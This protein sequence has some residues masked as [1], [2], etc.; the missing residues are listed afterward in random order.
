MLPVI[1]EMDKSA[2]KKFFSAFNGISFKRIALILVVTILLYFVMV[3]SIAPEKISI[4][5]G[6]IA[7]EDI[8]ASKEI[9]DEE[10]TERLKK[11]AID[12][13][14]LIHRVD[15]SVQVNI[16]NDVKNFFELV[17][18]IAA[19][20]EKDIDAKVDLIE[21][22]S[23][24]KLS[25]GEYIILFNAS[26]KTLDALESSIYDIINQIQGN[27]IKAEELEYEK[28]NVHEI[29]NS[30]NNIPDE[31][32]PTGANI[33]NSV[34][35]PNRFVDIET[36]H[37]KKEEAAA[38]VEPMVIKENQVIVERNQ[39]ID[40]RAY[41]LI[42]KSGL[43]KE[44]EGLDY[45]IIIGTLLIIML[46]ELIV[47]AYLYVLNKDTFNSFK[48]LL[49]LCIVMLSVIV[50]SKAIYGISP[51]LIPIS[52]A[53]MLVS[54]LINAK[55]AILINFILAIIIGLVTGNDVNLIIMLLIGGSIGVFGVINTNQRHN[56]FLTG[57]VVS[58]FN[59]LTIL[60]FGLIIGT[61]INTI[62]VSS[63]YGALNGI[64]SAILTIGSLPLWEGAFG[65]VTPLKLLELSNPNQPLLKKLLLEA[66]GTY[67]HS[68]V[69]G[70][71]S[72]SAAEAVKGN[73]LL[74][75]VGSYYHDIGKLKR[76][77]F[78]KENQMN[79][80]NP[81]DK[82]NPSMSTLIITNHVKDGVEFATKHKIP[83]IIKD[84]I[85]QHH[86]DT[87]VA[88]FYH[89]AMKGENPELVQAESFRYEGPKPQSKEAAIIMLADSVEAAVRAMPE[90][91]KGKMEV[92]VRDIIK[93]KLNDGQLD[94]CGLTLKDLN[95][96]ANSFLS[97]LVGI[98]HERIEYPKLDIN[99]LKES[100]ADGTS[101]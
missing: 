87:M 96:I 45:S 69:V 19:I 46:L 22:E 77:Y 24:I 33:V 15:P 25:Q 44:T 57:I 6:D 1:K 53:T 73:P 28:K 20:E 11:E 68:I 18:S 14:Q 80:D 3:E 13:I 54:I 55:L 92:L 83:Q 88:Y 43:L 9:I 99:E 74:A 67:H 90:P 51:Y 94:E 71:L 84:I 50:M 100:T 97:I 29:F 61:D 32:K 58:G 10:T 37:Q 66:P 63:M 59:I 52:A 60:G 36:T 7:T 40:E 101:N 5:I 30:L 65:I 39:I 21:T 72:E 34:I 62:I 31:I 89:K 75:R 23:S 8:R 76:P 17:D 2:I 16:K 38:Q 49:I 48:H 41:N 26:Q 93:G 47:I 70:N 35:K 56:I 82:L 4:N 98:F 91:T 42:R 27:G 95:T 64:F 78:F 85:K 12:R 86:G 81:H 79:K